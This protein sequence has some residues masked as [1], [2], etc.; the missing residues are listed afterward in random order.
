[1]FSSI[2]ARI[3]LFYLAILLITLSIMGTILY[4]SLSRI[5]YASV[6][7][8]LLSRAKALATLIHEGKQE[9]EFEFSDD[10]M[11]EYSS[12][13]SP[14][15]FQ[16]RRIDGTTIEKSASLEESELPY[17]PKAGPAAFQTVL[18]KGNS[19]RQI[20]F[21]I[22]KE[23]EGNGRGIVIQCAEDIR[24]RT[25]ILNTFGL[26]LA[27]SVLFIMILSASGGFFIAKRALNPVKNISETIDRVSETNLSERIADKNIPD[28]LKK[29]AASFNRVFGSL[30]MAFNRQRQFISDASHEL[31]TPLAII[32]SHGEV[33][34]RKDREPGE[35]RAALTAILEAAGMMSLI[36]GKLLTL[37]RFSSGP[38]ALQR[39]E[40][41][42]TGMIEKSLKLLRSLADEKGIVIHLAADGSHIVYGDGEALLEVFVNILDNAIKYN[43]SDGRIDIGVRREGDA[44]VT[45]IRDTGI[46]IPEGDL[47][48]IFDRFYRVDPS[49]TR[50][51]GGVG[52]GLSIANEIVKR[53][54]GRIGIES[55]LQAGTAVSVS[56]PTCRGHNTDLSQGI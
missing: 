8:S 50:K 51:S 52:L 37:A 56:L 24:D 15:F 13:K 35:Y 1:M 39:E 53:H 55:R 34:L 12:P 54:G 46:G 3:V 40:I 38:M 28:E 20:N 47:E 10:V 4:F 31:K 18:L 25:A 6:D 5:V 27:V 42:L 45:E 49:R 14:Y 19:I 11:W 23:G 36:I 26:V 33:T 43:V 16:I 29:I 32:I 44:V 22:R 17:D 30:E 21:P 48:K 2:K 7:S 41:A 9:T